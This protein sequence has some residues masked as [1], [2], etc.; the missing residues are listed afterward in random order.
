MLRFL[1]TLVAVALPTYLYLRV[2]SSVDRYEKEPTRYLV[3]AFLWGAIP[4][5]TV[6]IIIELI[7]GLPVSLVLG[8]KSLGG[9]LIS[10]AFIAPVVEEI[11]KGGA[12]AILYLW[13]RREF[14]GWVD[15]LVYGAT[16]GFGFAYVENLFYILSTDTWGDWVTLFFLRVVVFGLMHGFWTSLTGIGF[17]VARTHASTNN[18]VKGLVILLGLGAAIFSHM[19]HNGA[20]VLAGN[21]GGGTL[22]LAIGNYV[23]LLLLLVSLRIIAARN[24]RSLLQTY[25][26][27][28]AP[29][30]LSP[31]AYASLC[32]TRSHALAGLS[33]LG[34]V[35]RQQRAFIQTAAELAQKKRE[36]ARLGNT[37]G[38]GYEIERLRSELAAFGK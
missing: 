15:G 9:E 34:L 24:E 11:L 16:A 23:F 32:S 13:R 33:R 7:L 20:L 18:V 8:E 26:R 28:E 12:V 4:A 38:A 35:P 5:I 21:S 27:D 10:S 25:L 2:V 3:A 17:G 37:D 30:V 29:T 31:N 14:D 36:L 22:L 1:V 19:L 6:G